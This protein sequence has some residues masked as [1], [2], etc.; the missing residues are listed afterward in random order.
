MNSKCRLCGRGPDDIPVLT[1]FF[2]R[3]HGGLLSNRV[4]GVTNDVINV[5]K[6]YHFPGN[7]RELENE[8][9]AHGGAGQGR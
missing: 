4:I 1:E 9:R 8:V 7:V 2:V 6:A 3:K 5:L